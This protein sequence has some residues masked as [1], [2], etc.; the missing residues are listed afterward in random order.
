MYSCGKWLKGN[1]CGPPKSDAPPP[2]DATWARDHTLSSEEESEGAFRTLRDSIRHLSA[3]PL[4]VT[5]YSSS[6][7]LLA[8]DGARRQSDATISNVSSL[9]LSLL[10]G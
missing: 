6:S 1:F 9:A 5:R 10:P 8:T 2:D 3:S 4:L 7:K